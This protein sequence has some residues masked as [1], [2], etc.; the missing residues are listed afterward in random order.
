MRLEGQRA[1]VT[2]AATLGAF[3]S[4]LVLRGVSHQPLTIVILCV[5]LSLSLSRQPTH[6][7]WKGR[8]TGVAVVPLVAVGASSIGH[9]LLARANL[10]ASAFIVAMVAA[11]WLRQFGPRVA[12][13]ARLLTLPITSILVVPAIGV[14]SGSDDH[15]WQMAVALVALL[16]VYGVQAIASRL[17]RLPP[18]P[19]PRP[20]AGA[21]GAQKRKWLSGHTRMAVQL[22]VALT[23]A[24]VVGRIVFPG[25][26]N[27]TVLTAT[28][29]CGGGPSRGEVVAKGISRLMGAAVGTAGATGLAHLFPGHDADAVVLIFVL[30]FLGSWWREVQYAVW[31][32]CVTCVMAV[33]NDYL[34]TVDTTSLLGTRLEAI[35]AGAACAIVAS[36]CVLP[37]PTTSIVRKRRGAALA[38][39]ADI[40]RALPE[41]SVAA[42]GALRAFEVRLHE[43]RRSVRPLR[44]QHRVLG[45]I[46]PSDPV[47]LS[48]IDAVEACRAPA[49]AAVLAVQSEGEHDE[50]LAH[51]SGELIRAI[52]QARQLLAGRIAEVHFRFEAHD[53]RLVSLRDAV[54]AV[55]ATVQAPAPPELVLNGRPAQ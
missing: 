1:L 38:A 53:E 16:W 52:G 9:L 29:V 6:A 32:A 48:T 46:W 35:V 21:E 28:I 36:A 47:L 23:A 19:P 8:L 39:L 13:L 2:I 11:M 45:W 49:R 18:D 10:G 25:H 7:G 55:S 4:A 15:W 43:L 44:V 12:R 24:F 5:V 31:A 40:V 41:D 50:N 20:S 22:A 37:V 17:G 3:A 51:A 26:W 42:L 54:V 33:L 14:S 34:G 30:L 27:W